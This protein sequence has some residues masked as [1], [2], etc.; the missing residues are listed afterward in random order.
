MS[1]HILHSST[2]QIRVGLDTAL[3]Q[4]FVTLLPK[5]GSV[6]TKEPVST[7]FAMTRNGVLDAIQFI[8]GLVGKSDPAW[9]QLGA[10]A[11][12]LEQDLLNF[13]EGLDINFIK[14]HDA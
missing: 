1:C 11:S 3:T 10:V 12:A 9:N 14:V 2:Y 13:S 7:D 6:A 8:E 5:S 4:V